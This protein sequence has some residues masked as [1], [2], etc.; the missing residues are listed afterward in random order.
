MKKKDQVPPPFAGDDAA[1]IK[2]YERMKAE[3]ID[4]ELRHFGIDPR[5]TIEAVKKLVHD[6]LEELGDR[7]SLH[8]EETHSAAALTERRGGVPA[9]DPSSF[10]SRP[11]SLFPAL[12]ALNAVWEH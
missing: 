7:G 2:H 12:Q 4:A 6:K 1:A 10:R 11:T 5:P 8:E 3:E 9:I